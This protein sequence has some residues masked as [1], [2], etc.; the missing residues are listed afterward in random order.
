MGE[1]TRAVRISAS[2]AVCKSMKLL[3][4]GQGRFS[5]SFRIESLKGMF[6]LYQC[7]FRHLD[8]TIAGLQADKALSG[9]QFCFLIQDCKSIGSKHEEHVKRSASLVSRCMHF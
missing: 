2:D 5:F 1:G 4:R 3:H 8:M 6:K 7:T 9:N